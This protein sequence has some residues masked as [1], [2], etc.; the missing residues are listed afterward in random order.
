MAR[1]RTA[2]TR[3]VHHRVPRTSSKLEQTGIMRKKPPQIPQPAVVALRP[4]SPIGDIAPASKA[5][6]SQETLAVF[7]GACRE[8]LNQLPAVLGASRLPLRGQSYRNF[9][10]RLLTD[11][12]NPD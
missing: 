8:R 4:Q 6:M 3:A 12:G 11:S 1:V 2:G 5:T 7:D 10:N 9:V